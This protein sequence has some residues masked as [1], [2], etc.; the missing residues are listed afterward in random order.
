[1][2]KHSIVYW[3]PAFPVSEDNWNMLY[4]DINS[5]FD[6]IRGDKIEFDAAGRGNNFFYCPAFSG[7]T[8]STFVLTNPITTHFELDGTNLISKEKNYITSSA[9]RPSSI[10][11]RRMIEYGLQWAFFSED[12]VEMMITDTYFEEPKHAKYGNLIPGKF[13]ISKWFRLINLE[14]CLHTNVNEFRAEKDEAMAYV[15]F[16][17]PNPV[18]LVRFEITDALRQHAS[19][20][21]KSSV[22]ESWVPL[23]ARYKRFLAARSNKIILKEIK[24]NIL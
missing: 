2:S 18:K 13:N 8:R 10:V 4:P 11:N 1:M 21:G 3:A 16:H 17:A 22:W 12:D 20:G 5:V 9:F 15:H 19:T 7:F 14:Y 6:S 23:A 24:K